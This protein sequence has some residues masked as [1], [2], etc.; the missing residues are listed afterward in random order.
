MTGPNGLDFSYDSYLGQVPEGLRGQIEPSFKQYSE[1]IEKAVKEQI[2]QYEPYKE[3]LDQG[4]QP[5]HINV[6]LQFLQMAND[7]PERII[8]GILEEHPELLQQIPGLNNTPPVVPGQQTPPST[9]DSELNLPPQLLE[10]MNQQEQLI[11]LLFQG[12]QQ[13][14]QQTQEQQQVAQEQAELQQ[15]TQELDKIAPSNK[16]PR[17]FILSYI[18]QGQSPEQ[19]VKSFSDWRTSEFQ[20]QNAGATPLVA[21]ANGGGLP[22]E[23]VDTSKLTSQQRRD[24]MVQYLEQANQQK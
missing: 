11:Q 12:Y 6:G 21:P 2:G 3:I 22:S 13:N 23:T 1:G 5:E 19:A 7:N 17:H 4:W 14:Q 20:R 10:R 24:L 9:D 16:Y 15:F 18:S 8:Q